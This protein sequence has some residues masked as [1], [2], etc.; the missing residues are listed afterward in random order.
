MPRQPERFYAL[1]DRPPWAALWVSMRRSICGANWVMPRSI[2]RV[3]GFSRLRCW[4]RLRSS[5][6]N[7]W[8]SAERDPFWLDLVVRA[9]DKLGRH[10]AGHRAYTPPRCAA[11][12]GCCASSPRLRLWQAMPQV[13]MQWQLLG[14][15]LVPARRHVSRR[16]GHT[17]I[18]HFGYD[19]RH[20]HRRTV[21]SFLARERAVS[22][23][24]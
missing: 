23:R 22:V 16:R 18:R 10:R 8:N 11:S 7:R 19:L 9:A 24:R 15:M 14:A 6:G 3:G 1:Q 4:A 20:D 21:A 12:G 2:S 17:I 13:H 5:C